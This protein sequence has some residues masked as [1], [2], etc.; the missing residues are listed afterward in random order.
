[1]NLKIGKLDGITFFVEDVA[2]ELGARNIL[3]EYPGR[4]DADFEDTGRYPR[5]FTISGHLIGAGYEVRLADL[6]EVL[7]KKGSHKLEHPTRGALKVVL[8]DGPVRITRSTREGGMARV[9]MTFAEVG[10]RKRESLS[11]DTGKSLLDSAAATMDA[12]KDALTVG[13]LDLSGFNVIQRGA[14]AILAG[15][16]SLTRCLA[17]VNART[18]RLLGIVDDF[19]D[20]IDD[21]AAEV[22]TLLDTPE[23]LGIKMQGLINSCTHAV[24]SNV[25]KVNGGDSQRS[26]EQIAL[27]LQNLENVGTMGDGFGDIEGDTPS[28]KRARKNQELL[29][30]TV[31]AMML[32]ESCSALTDLE[33]TSEDDAADA[34]SRFGA[35]FDRL[36]YRATLDPEVARQL[37]RMRAELH[38]HLRRVS[39][40]LTGLDRYTPPVAISATR[41]AYKLYGDATRAAEIVSRNRPERPGRLHGGVEL[42]VA[43]E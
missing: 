19:S 43:R 9:T 24:R 35:I 38:G 42:G 13:P 8:I 7:E 14:A 26:S 21:F 2:D 25:R 4:L 16:K 32:C 15:P 33:I 41:L 28:N 1:M 37:L 11:L 3:H 20:A 5:R 31:E 17:Q 6:E 12:I 23:T 39:A 36:Q 29:V 34:L 10:E 40:D 30:D 27:L 18:Q 22:G